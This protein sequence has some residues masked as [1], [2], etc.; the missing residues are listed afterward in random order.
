MQV[1]V[2]LRTAGAGVPGSAAPHAGVPEALQRVAR[3]VGE[4]IQPLHPG[5]GDAALSAYFVIDVRDPK[6]VDALTSLLLQ[7]P[8][9]DAAYAKPP[10]ALP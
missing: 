4:V 9:V 7:S 3:S 1:I 10:D 8:L 2:K 6:R 5:T